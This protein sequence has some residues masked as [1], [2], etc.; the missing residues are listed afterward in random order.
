MQMKSREYAKNRI[1]PN[2]IAHNAL[3]LSRPY[4]SKGSQPISISLL[5]TRMKLTPDYA[6]E[7]LSLLLRNKRIELD[8]A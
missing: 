7:A 8:K 3:V 6:V 5:M 1:F 2:R 4:H